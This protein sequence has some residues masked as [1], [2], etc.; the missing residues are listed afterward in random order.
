M[1]AELNTTQKW[2]LWPVSIICFFIVAII[3]CV[4]FV[5]FCSRY[6][7]DL[8]SADYYE[9]EVRYQKQIDTLQR[10]QQ[11]GEAASV[12][13]DADRKQITVSLPKA[14]SS[15]GTAGSIQLYRPSAL[16][17]DRRIKLAPDANG[18]QTIDASDLL[19]GLWKVR[20]TWS[21]D[22]REFYVDQ[23]VVIGAKAS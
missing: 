4:S 9:Q 10:T 22:N 7:A 17:Q 15:A 23:K 6:P 16:D 12:S 11:S 1:S 21:V 20:V 19:P 3:G 2:N 5:V 13:Y 18:A 8:V 14:H